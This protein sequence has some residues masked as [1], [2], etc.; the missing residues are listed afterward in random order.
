VTGDSGH[1]RKSVTFERNERSRSAG[2]AGHVQPESAVRLARNT[3][4]SANDRL[5]LLRKLLKVNNLYEDK[6]VEESLK[7]YSNSTIQKRNVLAH[8]RVRVNGFS[9]KLFDNKGKEYTS[10]EM[11]KFRLE[12]LGHAELFE[13][14]ARKLAEKAAKAG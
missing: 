5:N 6:T 13:S 7:A 14:L 11:K 4:Y 8:V 10:E 9:R 3:H 2:T 1:S 12:L